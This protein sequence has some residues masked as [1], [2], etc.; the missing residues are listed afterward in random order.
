VAPGAPDPDGATDEGWVPLLAKS[1]L[2]PHTSHVFEDELVGNAG[3]RVSA[4]H[5]RMRI[6]PDGGVS[7]LRLFGVVSD[8]GRERA[9]MRYLRAMPDPELALALTACCG[10]RAWVEG[11]RA[12]RN[13]SPVAFSS[14]ATLKA[15]AAEIWGALATKD[16]DEAFRAHPRIGEQHPVG[17]HG[18]R[19]AEAAQSA[20][21]QGWSAAEQ[22]RVDTASLVTRDELRRANL[23]Y[24]E[25]FGRIYIVCAT[26]KTAEEMLAIA[27][28]RM[29][30]DPETELH[31]AALEQSRITDL[32]LE[33]LVLR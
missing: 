8:A 33:K 27:K 1:S 32:R 28:E 30:S 12:E 11:M 19:K 3:A 7:R 13:N 9:G 26:G 21:A 5:V 23:A 4:T 2:Q 16:W 20:V 24:E 14:L 31:R 25:R 17:Y 22:A 6:W 10:S 15:R 18:G 29:K